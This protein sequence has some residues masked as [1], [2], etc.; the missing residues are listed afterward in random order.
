MTKIVIELVFADG[1]GGKLI[2]KQML[3][4]I[5]NSLQSAVNHP[6]IKEL[7]ARVET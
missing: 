3:K 1:I 6:A 2:A 7:K 5:K 4:P